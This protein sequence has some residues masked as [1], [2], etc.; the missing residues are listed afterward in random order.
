MFE[1]KHQDSDVA[2]NLL[3]CCS[4]VFLFSICFHNI[5]FIDVH[6]S[7][8]GIILSYSLSIHQLPKKQSFQS[9]FH[10]TRMSTIHFTSIFIS[11]P[12]HPF[13]IS[14][15][16]TGCLKIYRLKQTDYLWSP[17]KPKYG[18]TLSPN[19]CFQVL[20][21]ARQ[22]VFSR[23]PPQGS[24]VPPVPRSSVHSAWHVRSCV[25]SAAAAAGTPG[26]AEWCSQGRR[27]LQG[28]SPRFWSL[29]VRDLWWFDMMIYI[30][31]DKSVL[32]SV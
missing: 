20:F 29:G 3:I 7:H 26:E 12:S 18:T 13:H 9:L 17:L 22:R 2:W 14:S 8:P 6:S 16:M 24:R 30:T 27:C 5:P 4:M 28:W 21:T 15:K 23:S 32:N 19:L 25:W 1:R 31:Y 10:T 11:M